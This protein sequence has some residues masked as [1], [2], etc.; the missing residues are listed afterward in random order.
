VERYRPGVLAVL[1][2][3]AYRI[4]FDEKNAELGMQARSIGATRVWVLPN[5][6][7]LKAHYQPRDLA[8]LF[9]EMRE[10]VAF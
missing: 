8:S 6:S 2:V 4:A 9:R 1:G 10:V 5:P 7:G 3:G